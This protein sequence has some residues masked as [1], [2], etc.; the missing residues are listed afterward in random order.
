MVETHEARYPLR[1]TT[2]LAHLAVAEAST[3]AQKVVG[4]LVVETA[5]SCGVDRA[6]SASF[7]LANLLP[8]L[9][10][11]TIESRS[12]TNPRQLSVR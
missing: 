1:R 9:R 7:T 10:V 2:F 8:I 4:V 6:K 5:V 3:L 12:E 11:E